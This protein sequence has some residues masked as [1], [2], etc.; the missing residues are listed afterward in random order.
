M[1]L[2]IYVKHASWPEQNTSHPIIPTKASCMV[3][4]VFCTKLIMLYETWYLLW[5]NTFIKLSS[6]A[7]WSS[8]H[9]GGWL[10]HV[11]HL[12]EANLSSFEVEVL[13]EVQVGSKWRSLYAGP[14]F[15]I[16]MSSNQCRKLHCREV[17]LKNLLELSIEMCDYAMRIHVQPSQTNLD[18]IWCLKEKV[19]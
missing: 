5:F 14:W 9:T 10:H 13:A 19:S 3:S 1:C 8:N 11:T 16:K 6:I 15:N 2:C 18:L 7:H 4:N 12:D 17:I